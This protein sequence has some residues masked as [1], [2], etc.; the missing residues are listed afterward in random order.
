MGA[1][2]D[3]WSSWYGGLVSSFEILENIMAYITLRDVLLADLPCSMAR[4]LI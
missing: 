1:E 3:A 2:N 4:T